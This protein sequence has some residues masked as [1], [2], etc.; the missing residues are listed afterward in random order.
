M[1]DSQLR[2]ATPVLVVGDS[3]HTAPIIRILEEAFTSSGG[4]TV[5]THERAQDLIGDVAGCLLTDGIDQ[6]LFEAARS[7][8]WAVIAV[9]ETDGSQALE[10]GA[11]DV[12]RHDETAPTVVA[13][14]RNALRRVT[15]EREQA[16]IDAA[17][18]AHA[19]ALVIV[20]DREGEVRSV[21]P[22]VEAELGYTPADLERMGLFALVHQTDRTE[23]REVMMELQRE[24][25]GSSRR[26]RC[27]IKDATGRWNVYRLTGMTR[28]AD[29]AVSG[30]V[31]TLTRA[32]SLANESIDA[33][34]PFAT[35]TIGL[36]GELLAFNEHAVSLFA[37]P[38]TVRP[39]TVLWELLPQ[40]VSRTL[41]DRVAE[42]QATGALKR[43]QLQWLDMNLE[44]HCHPMEAGTAIYATHRDDDDSSLAADVSYKRYESALEAVSVPTLLLSGTRIVGANT[45]ARTVLVGEQASL[46][47]GDRPVRGNSLEAFF[48]KKS[49]EMVA[50][51]VADRRLR[52]T[53]PIRTTT[54]EGASVGITIAPIA[55][56]PWTVC[57]IVR[58]PAAGPPSVVEARID[59][60]GA[61]SQL[62]VI[63]RLLEAVGRHCS[64]AVVAG[65]RLEGD[66]ARPVAARNAIT[67]EAIPVASLT[68][69]ASDDSG[70]QTLLECLTSDTVQYLESGPVVSSLGREFGVTGRAALISPLGSAWALVVLEGLADSIPDATHE[71]IGDYVADAATRLE[72]LETEA[73][74]ADAERRCQHHT[75]QL[76]RLTTLVASLE[77][78]T[79]SV[80]DAVTRETV[81]RRVCTAVSSLPDIEFA[82][83][84]G[85]PASRNRLEPRAIDG[86]PTGYLEAVRSERAVGGD[87]PATQALERG[88]SVFVV[89]TSRGHGTWRR[90]ALS[91]GIGAV[92][93]TP[94][95]SNPLGLGILSVYARTAT[96]LEEPTRRALDTL[97]HTVAIALSA[98]ETQRALTTDAAIELEVA[99][100]PAADTLCQVAYR[101]GD[102]L[103]VRMVLPEE[104]QLAIIFTVSETASETLLSAPDGV[105][106][107]SC[108]D[109][110]GKRTRYEAI[111]EGAEVCQSVIAAGGRPRSV[112]ESG[113]RLL[114][115]LPPEASVRS[116]L[117]AVR[118]VSP[119][120]SLL[121]RRERAAETETGRIF[122]SAVADRLT[123]RQRG[124]LHAA[125]E[126]GFF[127]WPRQ[128]TGE[129][130]AASLG[131]SQP[132]FARHFR[133]AERNLY[134]LLFEDPELDQHE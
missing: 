97:A 52:R 55:D 105:R 133:A 90:E 67:D 96:A 121:A 23:L 3:P 114:M 101:C 109:S 28:L 53:D 77:R 51:R 71:T 102:P 43:T 20:S 81:E 89:L 87:E 9:V 115:T 48:P 5:T 106:S 124:I 134:A 74:L 95:G 79:A 6:P 125:Y 2:P 7:H 24:P 104:E 64:G 54:E 92:Y 123:E 120:A 40:T 30:F 59:L 44:V 66:I 31:W 60:L 73:A 49:V 15:L 32:E 113:D 47:A 112:S 38:D 62:G 68:A 29:P 103:T 108:L 76:D 18:V 46:V 98:I 119:G 45:A 127:E 86:E 17:A 100:D 84:G 65:Y 107:L 110:D 91:R 94:I 41:Q 82:W 126:N 85:L 39:G 61:A 63:E 27:R 33:E 35:A 12:L 34:L 14:V 69:L 128:R 57:T 21:T 111:L 19:S 10:H 132:T 25:L 99:V 42:A 70:E 8:G 1:S 116:V 78:A 117:E 26:L 56:S 129:E 122:R 88:D 75:A 36:E 37:F 131:I 50:D 58:E 130:I 72:A 16:G 118:E 80:A 83:V 13:R 11:T 22:S 4:V 93:S